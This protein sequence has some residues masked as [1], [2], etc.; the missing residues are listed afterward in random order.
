MAVSVR[1]AAGIAV[2]FDTGVEA[3]IVL[4]ANVIF[5][6]SVQKVAGPF[7][8][9]NSARLS[10]VGPLASTTISKTSSVR[11]LICPLSINLAI[12]SLSPC[13]DNLMTSCRVCAE[14]KYTVPTANV[15]AKAGTDAMS[16]TVNKDLCKLSQEYRKNTKSRGRVVSVTSSP[17]DLIYNFGREYPNQIFAGSIR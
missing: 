13:D 4:A 3:G 6:V 5:L 11:L 7:K 8:K 1:E 17:S 10:G 15:S 16:K 14:S 9:R 2:G 12:P